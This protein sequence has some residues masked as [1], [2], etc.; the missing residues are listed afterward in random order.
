MNATKHGACLLAVLLGTAACV[1]LPVAQR[2]PPPPPPAAPVAEAPPPKARAAPIAHKTIT[3][4]G[5]CKRTEED[6]FR[7]DALMDV[8]ANKVEALTWKLWVSRR[9]SCEFNL[10]QFRQ[11]RTTPHIELHAIDGSQCKLLVWQDPRRVTLAHN[12]CEKYCT[13]GIYEQAW[14]VLFDPKSGNCA[15]VR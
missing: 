9:G 3:I 6:G 5:A 10:V 1:P 11:V 4:A 8:T 12:R 13:P 2:R 7:E 14:P 15:E